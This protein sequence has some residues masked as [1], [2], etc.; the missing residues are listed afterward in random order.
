MIFLHLLIYLLSAFGLAYIV[1]HARISRG[2]RERLFRVLP[3]F[4]EL[5]ECPA[6][7]GT[8]EGIFAGLALDVPAQLGFTKWY[9]AV[10]AFAL[11]TCATNLLLAR[12]ARLSKE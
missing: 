1:G 2:A 11:M 5:L 12:A 10:P 4:V 6:C 8:W 3:F 7:F 9:T